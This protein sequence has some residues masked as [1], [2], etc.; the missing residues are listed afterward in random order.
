VQVQDIF[1][2][3]FDRLHCCRPFHS[4]IESRVLY[5]RSENIGFA[6]NECYGGVGVMDL[7]EL[8]LFL[9]E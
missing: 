4:K 5:G 1:D 6:V 3:N 9:Y 8:D 2:L 7:L